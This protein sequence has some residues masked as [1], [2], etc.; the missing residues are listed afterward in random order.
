MALNLPASEI[1]QVADLLG[2]DPEKILAVDG[3]PVTEWLESLNVSDTSACS[4]G[5]SSSAATKKM[6]KEEPG[7]IKEEQMSQFTMEDIRNFIS[8][9]RIERLTVPELKAVIR[10]FPEQFRNVSTAG[11][12]ADLI[13]KIR[14]NI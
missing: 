2:P 10:S 4:L 11:K 7:T 8:D 13:E 5:A 6:K 12:K 9:G 1:G 14:I 3:E